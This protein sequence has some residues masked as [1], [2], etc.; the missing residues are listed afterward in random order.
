M[1]K[2]QITYPIATKM[3]HSCGIDSASD[4]GPGGDDCTCVPTAETWPQVAVRWA[5]EAEGV[6]GNVQVSLIEYEQPI[7]SDWI[8]RVSEGLKKE[9]FIRDRDLLKVKTETFSVVLCR[10][11]I[12]DLIKVL[13]RAR[14]HAY[15]R[16]E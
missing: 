16:D 11:E 8:Q 9:D 6:E 4:G 1:P 2:E 13:R 14:D 3:H 7:W 15:G 12:N 10:H 5:G